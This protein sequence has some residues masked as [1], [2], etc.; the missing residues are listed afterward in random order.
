[1][2]LLDLNGYR[3]IEFERLPRV[4]RNLSEL[5]GYDV[6]S[7]EEASRTIG[8]TRSQNLY[9]VLREDEHWGLGKEKE[10]RMFDLW[11]EK[12]DELECRKKE[13]LRSC[14][15]DLSQ[16][17]HTMKREQL[18]PSSIFPSIVTEGTGAA[19]R[20]AVLQILEGTHIFFDDGLFENMSE[21]E[22]RAL[23]ER[24]GDSIVH[25]AAHLSALSSKIF[26]VAKRR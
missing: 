15:V 10:T 6:L 25:L 18:P 23:K 14:L 3:I 24:H 9:P 5:I 12:R 8:Y 2:C 13:V 1:M 4:L 17:V 19:R 16:P 21:S 11:K 20:T 22:V 26:G 7:P